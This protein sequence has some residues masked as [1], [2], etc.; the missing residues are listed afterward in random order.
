MVSV[1]FKDNNTLY[2]QFIKQIGLT[3]EQIER[4]QEWSIKWEDPFLPVAGDNF[5]F[6]NY[7]DDDCNATF[8]DDIL[9]KMDNTRV[10]DNLYVSYR[11]WWASGGVSLQLEYREPSKVNP[12]KEE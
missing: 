8:S 5:R 2:D 12:R 10:F 4:M 11:E 7:F 1:W 9:K 3:Y 6:A